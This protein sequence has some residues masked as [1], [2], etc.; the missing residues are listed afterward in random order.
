MEGG[1]EYIEK[2]VACNR[3]RWSS[4][5]DVDGVVSVLESVS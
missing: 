4:G 2:E 5:L 1:G 3:K